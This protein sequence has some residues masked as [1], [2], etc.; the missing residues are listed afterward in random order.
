MDKENR[1]T[2]FFRYNIDRRKM[3][4]SNFWK[5]FLMSNIILLQRTGY[6]LLCVYVYVVWI[7]GM[8][9]R[10]YQKSLIIRR[11]LMAS[12][13]LD[14]HQ[15]KYLPKYNLIHFLLFAVLLFVHPVRI[16]K[17]RLH[18]MI[19]QRQMFFEVREDKLI[20]YKNSTLS[21]IH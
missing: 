20:S 21:T 7:S 8:D 3:T 14:H 11:I 5:I 17:S 1:K 6:Y 10:L 13:W 9:K 16:N 2:Q 19:Y 18:S 4:I 12:V 15:L